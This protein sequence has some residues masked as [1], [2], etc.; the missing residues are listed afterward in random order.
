MVRARARGRGAGRG[1]GRGRGG[2]FRR[3][4]R[5]LYHQ[6]HTQE[7]GQYVDED[8]KFVSTERR[9]AFDN[10]VRSLFVGGSNFKQHFDAQERIACRYTAILGVLETRG[11]QIIYQS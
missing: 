1:G 5:P 4:G 7:A 2:R 11:V 8:A 3:R 9:P 6:R 10:E